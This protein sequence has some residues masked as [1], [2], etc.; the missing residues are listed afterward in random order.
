M[1]LSVAMR[2]E[3]IVSDT[4]YIDRSFAPLSI[5]G[6]CRRWF[7][8]DH[9]AVIAGSE[10]DHMSMGLQQVEDQL[11]LA[12][13]YCLVSDA[14]STVH[15]Q[16]RMVCPDIVIKVPVFYV[17]RWL[18]HKLKLNQDQTEQ[19]IEW[20][21]AEAIYDRDGTVPDVEPSEEIQAAVNNA[22]S[23]QPLWTHFG[24]K[25]LAPTSWLWPAKG[26]GDHITYWLRIFGSG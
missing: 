5:I 21:E 6:K 18:I 12:P 20:F 26:H 11:H 17:I 3:N 10:Q 15:N 16:I 1:P 24:M 2:A 7:E 22:I 9:I 8:I 25:S 4:L 23:T 14:R 19:V 13:K